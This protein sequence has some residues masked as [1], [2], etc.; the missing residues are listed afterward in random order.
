MGENTFTE[1]SFETE[2]SILFLGET[3]CG[4]SSLIRAFLGEN[5]L[6]KLP[7]SVGVDTRDRIMKLEEDSLVVKMRFLDAGCRAT[8]QTVVNSYYREADCYVIVFDLQKR[9]TFEK[10]QNWLDSIVDKGQR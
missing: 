10:V 5:F 8:F 9:D 2:L 4:K 7:P 1:P 6:F 3:T